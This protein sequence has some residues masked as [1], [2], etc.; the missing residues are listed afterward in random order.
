MACD[1]GPEL[2]YKNQTKSAEFLAEEI[3]SNGGQVSICESDL[4]D[5]DMIPM[6]FDK[7]EELFGQVDI[8]VNN[9]SYYKTDTFIPD[10][11]L[12]TKD[13]KYGRFNISAIKEKTYLRHFDINTRAAALLIAEYTRRFLDK[14]LSEGSILNISAENTL[15]AKRDITYNASKAALESYSR[16]A[17]AELAR[18]GIRVNVIAPGAVQ[19]G[20]INT[21]A[22]RKILKRIPL[23]RLGKPEDIS[24]CALFL[25]SE[26][27]SWITGQVIGVNG[28]SS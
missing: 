14:G 20:W 26:K 13:S 3:R 16:T 8:L 17:A 7:A 1:P 10:A 25:C 28:G 15:G 19:T 18:F 22:E 9:A 27:A 11:Y 6:L 21:D 2:Y 5:P 23:K 24:A 4:S 12:E